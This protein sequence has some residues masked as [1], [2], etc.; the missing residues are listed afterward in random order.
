MS[1]PE[2]APAPSDFALELERLVGT[3]ENDFITDDSAAERRET[4]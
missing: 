2:P 4:S 3:V 1:R